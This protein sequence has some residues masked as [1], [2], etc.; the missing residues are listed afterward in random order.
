M[1]SEGKNVHFLFFFSY[2]DKIYKKRFSIS[3]KFSLGVFKEESSKKIYGYI[4][5]KQI[6]LSRELVKIDTG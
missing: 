1:Q 2:D 4:S 5:Q 3:L 6:Q